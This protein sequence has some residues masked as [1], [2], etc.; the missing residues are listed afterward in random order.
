MKFLD[1]IKLREVAEPDVGTEA[2]PIVVNPEQEPEEQKPR[3]TKICK[4][5]ND[6]FKKTKSV[7]QN[8][9]LPDK[10]KFELAQQEIFKGYDLIV[11]YLK[12]YLK[13]HIR[14][15]E[16]Q[17][18]DYDDLVGDIVVLLFS[19]NPDDKSKF[20]IDYE[21]YNY[22]DE[23]TACKM[24]NDIARK[25]AL[26]TIK[27]KKLERPTFKGSELEQLPEK[28]R[29]IGRVEVGK[30]IASD[31]EKSADK[32]SDL[33]NIQTDNEIIVQ[34]IY[35]IINNNLVGQQK[36]V[37]IGVFVNQ[38]TQDDLAKGLGTTQ[39]NVAKIW[40]K[41][42]KKILRELGYTDDEIEKMIER[43]TKIDKK[44]ADGP[45]TAAVMNALR[46]PDDGLP[47]KLRH[48]TTFSR[49]ADMGDESAPASAF[50]GTVRSGLLKKP[51]EPAIKRF[52]RRFEG[53]E[54]K[55]E[56]SRFIQ[57]EPVAIKKQGLYLGQVP[58][59]TSADKRKR[60]LKAWWAMKPKAPWNRPG[61]ELRYEQMVKKQIYRSVVDEWEEMFGGIGW[62]AAK[63][64]K[65]ED[66]SEEK[67][68]ERY[69]TWKRIYK[70]FIYSYE[71]SRDIARK[72]GDFVTPYDKW[73]DD[74]IYI[75]KVYPQSPKEETI[76][77]KPYNYSNKE[78]YIDA[79]GRY[80]GVFRRP[81][82]EESIVTAGP[83]TKEID[84]DYYLG[85][86]YYKPSHI[87][88]DKIKDIA[89]DL[90]NKERQG[91]DNAMKAA[92]TMEKE[93]RGHF[94]GLRDEVSR[95]LSFAVPDPLFSPSQASPDDM[96]ESG[97]KKFIRQNMTTIVDKL[98]SIYPNEK[99]SWIDNAARSEIIR[100]AYELE[101]KY[102][103]LRGASRPSVGVRFRGK[104][105]PASNYGFAAAIR[106]ELDSRIQLKPTTMNA[107]PQWIQPWM[108]AVPMTVS[109]ERG[110][111]PDLE[112]IALRIINDTQ[113][114]ETAKATADE[115][116]AKTTTGIK[117]KTFRKK[118]NLTFDD[119]GNIISREL[120]DISTKQIPISQFAGLAN[121]MKRMID[122]IE[123][124][125]PDQRD[126]FNKISNIQ[127]KLA[128][129]KM[130]PRQRRNIMNP[131]F[132]N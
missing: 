95:L 45:V 38:L 75:N 72:N 57:D 5:L 96:F 128:F 66:E 52:Y 43:P 106:K 40:K 48:R 93:G 94:S 80:L 50:T 124:M 2:D 54:G 105:S 61:Q 56:P 28:A 34:K 59:E 32:E 121:T 97:A 14:N 73:I 35:D 64:I 83:Q 87:G 19:P 109:P 4:P 119:Q 89:K 10:Q 86:S 84:V 108:A 11:R 15:L 18:I 24:L 21:K 31:L 69:K 62:T 122:K 27:R 117:T 65:N 51:G 102:P 88:T 79:I 77:P 107:P 125:A 78:D 58:E 120:G 99:K 92:V 20:R 55:P 110:R 114:M 42:K 129:L 44:G 46:T 9:G 90:V 71:L 81:E 6:I 3:I 26:A 103:Q 111:M 123:R 74:L 49:P 12:M 131:K 67:F 68:Q 130:T 39:Q 101:R 70:R 113:D 82:E 13:R 29:K 1:F 33:P 25:K 100:H 116:I 126:H 91:G 85:G 17:G 41:A 8:S 16:E 37:A 98:K 104:E 22:S 53:P 23:Q 7:I 60:L 47:R 30:N 118:P 36:N 63:P 127:D 112:Q 115:L 132:P 76:E